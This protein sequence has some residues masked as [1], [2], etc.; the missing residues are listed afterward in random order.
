MK[1]DKQL[2]QTEKDKRQKAIIEMIQTGKYRRQSAIVDE[3]INQDFTAVQGT[4][5]RDMREMKIVEGKDGSSCITT[6][7]LQDMHRNE[8]QRLL[9]ENHPPITKILLFT[10]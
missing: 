8:L 7:P 2:E 9:R 4:V 3:L 5:S 6:E 10:T 1:D